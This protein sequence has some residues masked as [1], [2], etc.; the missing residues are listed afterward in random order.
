VVVRHIASAVILVRGGWATLAV[1]GH[2]KRVSPLE[3]NRE[4]KETRNAFGAN[5]STNCETTYLE[6]EWAMRFQGGFSPDGPD[7]EPDAH[8]ACYSGRIIAIEDDEVRRDI[9]RMSARRCLVGGADPYFVLDAEAELNTYCRLFK[10]DGW[11]LDRV[12][13]ISGDLLVLDRL[14]LVPEYRR[15]GLGL[16][17]IREAIRE[18]GSGCAAVAM[19]PAALDYD[20]AIGTFTPTEDAVGTKKLETYYR[21]LGFRRLGNILHFDLSRRM[22]LA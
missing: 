10:A 4:A 8:I 17:I 1:G 9:G 6:L 18:L 7:D 21:R 15:R 2:V 19:I 13:E 11:F 14:G 12:A 22:E 20:H 16:T 5:S 3:G